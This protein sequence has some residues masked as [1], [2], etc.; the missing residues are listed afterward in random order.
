MLFDLHQTYNSFTFDLCNQINSIKAQI[1]S[2][3][4]L[5]IDVYGRVPYH[6]T[7]LVQLHHLEVPS[8]PINDI[9][10]FSF[11]RPPCCVLQRRDWFLSGSRSATDTTAGYK[12]PK[13]YLSRQT[14][15]D[16]PCHNNKTKTCCLNT[17]SRDNDSSEEESDDQR[18]DSDGN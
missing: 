2:E 7:M 18:C 13:S 16:I 15:A 4:A 6:V 11:Y 1:Y 9:S 17:S 5:Y 14:I 12:A 8:S 10:S 3:Y